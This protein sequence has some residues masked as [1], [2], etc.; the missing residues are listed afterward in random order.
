MSA[1][2]I[3]R[4]S[5]VAILCSVLSASRAAALQHAMGYSRSLHRTNARLERAQDRKQ[6]EEPIMVRIVRLSV[7]LAGLLVTA[8]CA[9]P[10]ALDANLKRCKIVKYSDGI[11]HEVCFRG[12]HYA[13]RDTGL[14]DPKLSAEHEPESVAQAFAALGP[15]TGSPSEYCWGCRSYLKMEGAAAAHFW[16][17]SPLPPVAAPFDTHPGLSQHIQRPELSGPQKGRPSIQAPRKPTPAPATKPKDS[18]VPGQ[19]EAKA[20]DPNLAKNGSTDFS[21]S[22]QMTAGGD[23]CGASPCDP[24]HKG[25][26]LLIEAARMTQ[27]GT[28][29]R[30]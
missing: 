4:R 10:P 1:Y 16:S 30:N 7:A 27:A 5:V 14:N 21:P 25:K 18:V 23:H 12:Q 22:V 28:V 9:T 29:R 3:A 2:D 19:I 17:D 24:A 26:V 6:R 15:K 8:A 20:A 13:V 11:V